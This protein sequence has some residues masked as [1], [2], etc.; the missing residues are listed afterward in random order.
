MIEIY[1]QDM[2]GYCKKAV[3]LCEE[4]NLPYKYYV[5]KEDITLEEFKKMFPFKRTVPQ[6]NIDGKYIGGFQEL[7]AELTP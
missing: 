3:D 2:C 4:R 1:G 5:V 6:I 7:K